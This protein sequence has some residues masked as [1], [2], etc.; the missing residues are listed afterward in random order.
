L[1]SNTKEYSTTEARFR[2]EKA[3]TNG[4]VV[5]RERNILLGREDNVKTDIREIDL[6]GMCGAGRIYMA[7]GRNEWRAFVNTLMNM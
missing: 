7:Q 5:K 1:L 4:S 2:R 3:C 6:V